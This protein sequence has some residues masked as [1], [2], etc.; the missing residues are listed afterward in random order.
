M[1]KRKA[2]LSLLLLVPAPSVG[3]LAGMVF[4]PEAPLGK[5]VFAISKIWLFTLPAVWYLLVEK[6]KFGLSPARKGGFGFGV[7]S[8]LII[9]GIILAG[10]FLLGET[11]LDRAFLVEKM[12]EIGLDKPVL[13]AGGAPYWVG[14]NSVLEEYVWRWFVVR[15]CEGFMK[16]MVA[17]AAAA[18]FF[19]LHHTIALSTFMPPMATIVCSA[20]IF[21]GGAVWS[22]MY[23]KYES[24]WPGYLSHAIVD[25]CI[26]ALGAWMIFA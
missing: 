8:G 1:N 4:W 7:L 24:I 21:I 13:Y 9:S 6:G 17:V 3:V 16:P 10:Y 26:F 12:Q 11:F 19:T 5:T 22:W 20:G 23:V 18:V 25:L 15:Q 14:V 2:I